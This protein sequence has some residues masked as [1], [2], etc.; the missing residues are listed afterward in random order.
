M[1]RPIVLAQ[2]AESQRP[3]HF[4]GVGIVT[5]VDAKAGLIDLD[6]EVASA[7]ACV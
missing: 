7:K 3:K 6:H 1:T 2:A 4:H 5:A